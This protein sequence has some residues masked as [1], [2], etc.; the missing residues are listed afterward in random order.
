VSARRRREGRAFTQHGEA[1]PQMDDYLQ[2][3]RA[4][5]ALGDPGRFVGIVFPALEPI[6]VEDTAGGWFLVIPEDL[7]GKIL[8]HA[9][10]GVYTP[11]GDV[12]LMVH[13]L[14]TATDMLTD[15]IQ[16]DSGDQ[17][18]YTSA[19]P[20]VIDLDNRQVSTGDIIVPNVT[21]DGGATGLDIILQFT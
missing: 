5:E 18:S 9:H 2:R 10:A 3:I 4:L 21:D 17:T 12:I 19:A 1:M 13:N 20:P 11:G 16:V 15:P 7:D 14:T 6:V 8:T